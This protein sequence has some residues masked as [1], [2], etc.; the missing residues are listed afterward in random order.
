LSAASFWRILGIAPTRDATDIRRAYA[1][2]LKQTNPEDDAEGFQALRAAYEAALRYAASQPAKRRRPP[3]PEPGLEPE[4]EPELGKRPQPEPSAALEPTPTADAKPPPERQ[5]AP[6]LSQPVATDKRRIARVP[7]RRAQTVFV[8]VDQAAHKALCDHLSALMIDQTADRAALAQALKAVLASPGLES[9]D[10]HQRTE[11]WLAELIARH[12]GRGDDLIE[13]LVDHF[14]WD[15][16]VT[17]SGA[18]VGAQVLA[19]REGLKLLKRLDHPDYHH[20]T[21]YRALTARPDRLTRWRWRISLGLAA[22]VR[23]LIEMLQHEHPELFSTLDAEA[24]AW[25]RAYLSRPQY[26]P[27]CCWSLIGLPPVIA[28]FLAGAGHVDDAWLIDYG[29][30]TLVLLAL[31]CLWIFAV[32]RP[33][34]VWREGRWRARP[35][36]LRLGWAPAALGLLLVNGLAPS[37]AVITGLIALLS[38]SVAAWG[39]I[40]GETDT[41]PTLGWSWRPRGYF[42]AILIVFVGLHMLARPGVGISWRLRALTNFGYLI[43][44]WPHLMQ[45]MSEDLWW[46]SCPPLAAALFVFTMGDLSL[47]QAWRQTLSRTMR[48]SLLAGLGGLSLGLASALW[49][50]AAAPVATPLTGALIA[51]LVI[52]HKPPATQLTGTPWLVR[53]LVMRYGWIVWSILSFSPALRPAVPALLFGGSWLLSGVLATAIGAALLERPPRAKAS[54][55]R[56]GW[57]A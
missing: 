50:T 24:L 41:R 9:L 56:K 52:A 42:P 22:Q 43:L 2:Q 29:L 30:S 27:I 46:R 36:W 35:L 11:R 12:P 20:H 28:L 1:R 40:T 18:A 51:V 39:F 34:Q 37:S 55:W 3:P 26:G 54:G 7:A 8:P 13:P 14:G 33:R 44:F 5:P 53:D 38:V 15:R 17:P 19:R 49:I 31:Q 48:L 4:A 57:L 32:A 25:W 16:R 10:V 47:A 23:D 6:S 21:A 45:P